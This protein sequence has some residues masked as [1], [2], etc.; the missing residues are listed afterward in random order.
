MPVKLTI[1]LA[2]LGVE[3]D[4]NYSGSEEHSAKLFFWLS[5]S[6]LPASASEQ[7]VRDWCQLYI[8]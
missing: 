1:H 8:A 5:A 2:L 4:Q 7:I 6:A 3:S